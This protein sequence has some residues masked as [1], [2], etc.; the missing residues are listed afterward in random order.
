MLQKLGR[1]LKVNIR[2]E[3]KSR[4]AHEPC[5]G[6]WNNVTPHHDF[7]KRP[8]NERKFCGVRFLSNKVFRELNAEVGNTFGNLLMKYKGIFTRFAAGRLA[9]LLAM[10]CFVPLASADTMRS[11]AISLHQGWNAIFLQVTPTNAR[12]AD[13]FIG[14]PV[15]MVA[16]FIGNGSGVQFVQN[17]STN[18]LNRPNGWL[19]WYA[20]G[21]PDAF[22]TQLFALSGNASYLVYSQSDFTW[23]VTGNV[24]ITSVTWKPNS[25][26]LVGFGLDDLSPPTFNQFFDG[27]AE[28]HPYRIYR[29]INDNWT[30]V[31]QAQTT[32]MRSGEAYWIYCKGSSDYQGPLYLKAPVGETLAL[33]GANPVGVLLAN[34]SKNPLSVRVENVSGSSALP[35]AFVLRAVTETNIVATAFDLPNPYNLPSFDA[36]ESRGFWLTTR[37]EQMTADTQTGLLK[38]TTDLGTQYWLPVTASRSALPASN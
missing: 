28:H 19:A 25:F 10:S 12:P 5:V 23:S 36:G 27:S 6:S 32:Q 13:C 22:L 15:T 2:M 24:V 18:S 11:Q 14:T 3:S 1:N 21:R 20:P 34:K 30:L 33:A 29:L 9:G 38:I 35:L 7:K 4:L 16:S 26:S 8:W 17:P 31:D 37:T